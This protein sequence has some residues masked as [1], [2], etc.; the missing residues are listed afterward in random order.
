MIISTAFTIIVVLLIFIILVLIH[1]LGHFLAAKYF[2]MEVE[3]FGFGLPPRIWGKKIGGTL[4]SINALPF[5]GFVKI[6]GEEE[7]ED[8]DK[9]SEKNSDRAF[10]NYPKKQRLVVLSAGVLMNF[11]LATLVISYIFTKGVYMPSDMVRIEEVMPNS[12]AEKSGLKIGDTI[13]TVNGKKIIN[14]EVFRKEI[15]K[16][17][18]KKVRIGFIRKD[19]NGR[20]L[21]AAAIGIP[22]VKYPIDQ[23]PFGVAISQFE[24]KT[25]PWYQ[26][27]FY[28][29]KE[30]F[31]L[32]WQMVSG[33]GIILWRL[34]TMAEV[35]KDVAGP[36]GIGQI[37]GQAIKYG[38]MAVVQLLGLLS[39][40]LAV[41]NFLPIPG[42]DGGRAVFV[43]LEKV[44]GRKVR[45]KIEQR[46]HQI[47]LLF[48]F[49]L[50]ILVTIN[51]V[52]RIVKNTKIDFF[53]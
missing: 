28:G 31:I 36:I 33:L 27:P 18:G 45:V 17:K 26:A 20:V 4:Y 49:S 5:G 51:D 8:S 50:A 43:I 24:L 39:L 2:G 46:A 34:V 47:G 25:Y 16:N 30:A 19:E 32:S 1:E 52:L 37:T 6:H 42:L 38:F 12:P 13:N 40:N 11:L 14:T 15:D 9:S 29:L 53:R 7:T 23:G 21:V 35:P 41:I 10:Y 48:L 44:I 22:R 3:E